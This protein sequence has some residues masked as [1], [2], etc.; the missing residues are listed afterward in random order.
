MAGNAYF[1]MGYTCN[2]NCVI[3]PI[4]AKTKQVN[5]SNYSEAEI[6]KWIRD[7][8]KNSVEHIV[9]S[10]GEPTIQPIFIP[11]LKRLADRNVRITLLSNGENFF[12]NR[13]I[14]EIEAVFPLDRMNVTI[15][16]HG[17]NANLHEKICNAKGSFERTIKGCMNIINSGLNLTLKHCIHGI[18]ADDSEKFIDFIFNTFPDQIPLIICEIDYVGIE[19][20]VLQR[21]KLPFDRLG[22]SIEKCL[23]RVESYEKYGCRRRVKV[24]ETP[25]CIVDPYYWKYFSLN[26]SDAVEVYAENKDGIKTYDMVDSEC[27]KVYN[28]CNEC[29]IKNKCPGVWKSSVKILSENGLMSI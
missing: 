8:E 23:D 12:D 9:L 2:H 3:C 17:S 22:E 15:A 11:V 27:C 18:N 20:D 25:L 19:S 1:A 7:I 6:E 5:Q 28:V 21:V 26:L 14:K 29:R 24:V 4:N 13:L 16:F 10:G